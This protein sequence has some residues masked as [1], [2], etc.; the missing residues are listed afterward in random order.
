MENTTEISTTAPEFEVPNIKTVAIN[1]AA[2]AV[3]GVAVQM[4]AITVFSFV[5]RKVAERRSSRVIPELDF[6]DK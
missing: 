1:A 6:T 3:I 5:T 2:G 4:A